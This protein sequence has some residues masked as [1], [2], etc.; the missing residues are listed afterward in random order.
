[1]SKWFLNANGFGNDEGQNVWENTKHRQ[2]VK[3][4]HYMEKNSLPNNRPNISTT[5]KGGARTD[6]LHTARMNRLQSGAVFPKF[7]TTQPDLCDSSNSM[8]V[9]HGN[10]NKESTV[11]SMSTYRRD[12]NKPST[13]HSVLPSPDNPLKYIA[14]DCEMVGTGPKGSCSEL[15]RCS[16][17]SYDGDLIY[18]KFIK[19]ENPVT[20]FRTRWSGIRRKDLWNATPFKEAQTEILKI[21]SGKVVVGHA[22]YND[23]KVLHYSHPAYLIRDT[24]RMPILNHKAGFPENQI[25]SL[26]NLTKALLNMD[27]QVGRK[28]H[29]SIEDAKASM[30]LYKLVQVEWEK[31]GLSTRI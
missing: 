21:I 22:I 28:G 9:N 2:F 24:S 1:M 25:V 30:E 4:R 17:V 10:S 20:N 23:F 6:K 13:R 26:K 18:D 27:I 5:Q 14:L 16:I 12:L 15:A 3:K 11:P 7:T 31:T 29:S 8:Q 19:P